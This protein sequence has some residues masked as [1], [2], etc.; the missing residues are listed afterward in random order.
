MFR[1][2]HRRLW[3]FFAAAGVSFAVW[4]NIPGSVV[5]RT[6]FRIVAGSFANPPLL[7]SGKG[8][9]ESPWQLRTVA[10]EAK[11]DPKQ[12]PVVISLGNDPEG[13]FQSSPPSPSDIGILFS[14]LQRLG[15][16]KAASAAVLSWEEPDAISLAALDLVMSKFESVVTTSPLSRGS[17]PSPMPASYRRASLPLSA[18]QGNAGS[19]PLVNRVPIPHVILGG[20]NAWSGF[21]LLES[22]PASESPALVARWEDRIVFS[23]P[24]LVVLQRHQLPLDGV[25]IKPGEAIWLSARG[26]VV[27]IDAFGHLSAPLRS[28]QERPLIPA[29]SLIDAKDGIFPV[30]TPGPVILRDDQSAAEPATQA[31]SKN[32]GQVISAIASE[33][34]V[35]GNDAYPR[36][37][38]N[39]EITL[40]ALISLVLALVAGA[41]RNM[42]FAVIVVLAAGAQW[43]SVG[44]ANFWLPML[45]VIAATV[46]A[47]AISW[48][49]AGKPPE[50][51]PAILPPAVE[52]TVIAV[53]TEDEVV[54]MVGNPAPVKKS[55][56]KKEPQ[57]ELSTESV[58]GTPVPPAKKAAKKAAAKKI[59]AKKA[60][61][62]KSARKKK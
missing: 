28:I 18:V 27:P 58:A 50:R 51:Q 38:K 53:K 14:N 36:L 6:L 45:P 24:L 10:T 33:A 5:D 8:T 30:P 16:K 55:R 3:V 26:P 31:F 40:L 42:I 17:V 4:K 48:R 9:H 52:E 39:V 13:I 32:L 12:A 29:E 62:K 25:I 47:L 20:E 49:R 54:P 11:T 2:F 23:F 35:K 60:A 59:T 61:A 7:V 57:A 44:V 37:S 41:R 22:E 56:K 46:T 34:G 43:I 19:L 21:N 1:S 15:A